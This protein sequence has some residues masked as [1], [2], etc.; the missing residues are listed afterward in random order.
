MLTQ[1][2]Q[3]WDEYFQHEQVRI[4]PLLTEALEQF[5]SS[6]TE[7]PLEQWS[8]WA[9]SL[10]HQYVEEGKDIPIRFPL[11]RHVLFPVLLAG[12]RARVRNLVRST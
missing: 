11:F 1:K 4:R 7:Q 8:D 2:Q 10:C 6:V 12:F 3:L 9:L 5:V